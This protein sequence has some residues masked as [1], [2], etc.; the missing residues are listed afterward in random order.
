MNDARR[1]YLTKCQQLHR[2]A[3][4]ACVDLAMEVSMSPSTAVPI[5]IAGSMY[6]NLAL[7]YSLIA[8][9]AGKKYEGKPVEAIDVQDFI[10]I[11]SIMLALMNACLESRFPK[12]S[13][14]V[15]SAAIKVLGGSEMVEIAADRLTKELGVNA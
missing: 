3:G 12:Q 5:I 7:A 8:S 9:E 4:D 2:D 10:R 13:H 1:E 15:S 14:A 6:A 11:R